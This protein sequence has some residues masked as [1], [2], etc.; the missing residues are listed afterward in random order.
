MAHTGNPRAQETEVGRS[1][2]PQ[3]LK[4][5]WGTQRDL[6]SETATA[7]EYTQIF[8]LIEL[9]I[10]THCCS[11]STWESKAGRSLEPK[12]QDPVSTEKKKTK[13][14]W[15]LKLIRCSVKQDE[16]SPDKM[17]LTTERVWLLS[18]AQ[19]S[20]DSSP[21]CRVQALSS[22]FS[23]TKKTLQRDLGGW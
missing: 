18:L 17:R 14:L 4:P 11:S 15:V 9:C 1:H 10:V 2:E 6:I 8:H 19:G 16:A 23:T 7:R 12:L 22:N 21:A 20:T 3:N 5:A 13:R